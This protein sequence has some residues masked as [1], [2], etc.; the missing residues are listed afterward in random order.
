MIMAS[1]LAALVHAM[2]A[3]Q[4]TPPGARAARRGLTAGGLDIDADVFIEKGSM[5]PGC[6]GTWDR[7]LT[8]YTVTYR[9]T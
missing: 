4:E 3:G 6:A 9:L 7:L 1:Q 8:E 5:C 2:A